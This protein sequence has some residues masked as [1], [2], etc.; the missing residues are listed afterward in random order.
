MAEPNVSG[1]S[2]AEACDGFE[3]TRLLDRLGLTLGPASR[4][5]IPK[6]AELL[7]LGAGGVIDA[8]YHDLI[9]GQAVSQIVQRRFRREDSIFNYR[10]CQVARERRGGPVVAHLI[11]YPAD[12]AA[13]EQPDPLI[14]PPRLNFWRPLR[15]LSAA[16]TYYLSS[17]A[18]LPAYQHRGLGR[19]LL[20]L[21]RC[22][23]R[24]AGFDLLSL[25][26]FEANR[27]ALK[28]YRAFG[29]AEAGRA[30]SV[31]HRLIR[32]SGE[33]LLLQCDVGSADGGGEW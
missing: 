17:L 3:A 10:N 13:A 2:L 18:V 31:P 8:V 16:G 32:F 6:L 27:Q 12:R 26:V 33:L 25:H 21:S 7:C 23:A 28:L 29:F 19:A 24:A 14:P 5:D 1:G 4:D 15:T 20:A 9:P 30:P 11:S 22:R